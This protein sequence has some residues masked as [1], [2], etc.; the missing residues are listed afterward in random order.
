MTF[1]HQGFK[2]AEDLHFT[3]A[4]QISEHLARVVRTWDPSFEYDALGNPFV[5]Q[6]SN[7]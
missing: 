7:L 1:L 2:N 3:H 6:L 4:M 5:S